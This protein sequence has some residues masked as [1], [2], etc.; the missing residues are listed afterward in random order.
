MLFQCDVTATGGPP[1]LDVSGRD[2]EEDDIFKTTSK[3]H[4]QKR[5]L[6]PRDG[7][8]SNM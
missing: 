2:D 4:L 5:V 3:N 7:Y 6:R 1:G 8:N